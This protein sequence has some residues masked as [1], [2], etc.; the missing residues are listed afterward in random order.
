PHSLHAFDVEGRSAHRIGL[1][2]FLAFDDGGR[3]IGR[4]VTWSIGPNDMPVDHRAALTVSPMPG[5][6][7]PAPPL[8]RVPLVGPQNR[9]A[10]IDLPPVLPSGRCTLRIDA[11]T[12][13][14]RGHVC[15]RLDPIA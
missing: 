12:V 2:S 9:L 10:Q 15:D 4:S 14:I 5:D 6:T 8:E 3:A 11:V 13:P 1:G 7:R